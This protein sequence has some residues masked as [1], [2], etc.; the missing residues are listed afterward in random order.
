RLIMIMRGT[1]PKAL[2]AVGLLVM[3][4]LAAM[5]LPL[6]PTWARTDDDPI[7]A[8]EPA[9]VATQDQPPAASPAAATPAPEPSPAALAAD[10]GDAAPA[11]QP[12][13]AARSA[14]TR[15]QQQDHA[16]QLEDAKEEVELLKVQLDA[17]RAESNEAKVLVGKAQRDLQRMQRL[18]ANNA[19]GAEDVDRAQTEL[20]VQ[21]ARLEGKQAQIQEAEL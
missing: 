10:P 15:K 18:A 12:A 1:T 20:E 6:R 2:S 16:E 5:L 13:L 7:A 21:Q 17:K 8:D 11:P 9:T 3:L 4:G 19:V 14:W